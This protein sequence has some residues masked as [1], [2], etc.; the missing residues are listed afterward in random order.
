MALFLVL[1]SFR[2]QASELWL[3]VG[4]TRELPASTAATVRIGQRGVIRVVESG[5]SIR[6]IGLKPGFTTLALDGQVHHVRVS[7]SGQKAFA[8]HLRE[9]LKHMMG[10]RLSLDSNRLEIQGTLLRFSDWLTLAEIARQHQGEY[11]FRAKA[12]ADVATE[13]LAHFRRLVHAHGLPILRFSASPEFTAHFPQG[14]ASMLKTAGRLLSPFGIGV[15]TAPAEIYIQPLVRTRVI[16]AE[17]AK[18]FSRTFGL[19]WPSE[20]RAQILPKEPSGQEDFTASLKALEAEGRAQILASPNLL[21]RS[22]GEARFHAGGEFPIRMIGRHS[23]GVSWK[24][25]GVILNVRPKADFQG[26]IS[27]DVETEVSLL[28]MAHA[29]EG[30]PAIKKSSVKSHFDL[31]GRRTIVLSG[32]LR[33]ETGESSEGLPFLSGIPLLGRL[34]ASKSYLQHRSELVVFVTPEIHTPDLDEPVQMP[35]GWVTNAF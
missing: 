22:G 21:C 7:L 34:F 3:K 32:L 23:Q 25:H 18:N 29:V 35:E 12:H 11:T 30:V 33:Q 5:T 19:Q 16:L 9:E 28:D 13:A 14:R 26:A 2:L 4:E 17:V 10:L 1:F 27:L 20:Y 31:P 24:P 15:A 8:L 6:L